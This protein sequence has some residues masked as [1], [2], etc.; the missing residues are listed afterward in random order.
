ML[1]CVIFLSYFLL[2]YPDFLRDWFQMCKKWFLDSA[3]DDLIFAIAM[4][5]EF[6]LLRRAVLLSLFLGSTKL[7]SCFC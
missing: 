5:S 6:C 7:V 2:L 1:L 3:R 4:H